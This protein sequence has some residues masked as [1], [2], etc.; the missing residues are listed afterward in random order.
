MLALRMAAVAAVFMLDGRTAADMACS[1]PEGPGLLAPKVDMLPHCVS[2]RCSDKQRWGSGNSEAETGG[3]RD[4]Q[5]GGY[6]AARAHARGRDVIVPDTCWTAE[7]ALHVARPG[8]RVFFR[9]GSF[10]WDDIAVVRRHMHIAGEDKSCLLGAWLLQAETTGLFQGV[11]CAAKHQGEP[12]A[13]LADATVTSLSASW[14]FEDCELRAVRGPVLRLLDSANVTLLFC[15][16]GGVGGGNASLDD[17]LLRATDAVVA[18]SSS[19][20]LLYRCGIDDTGDVDTRPPRDLQGNIIS[21]GNVAT[22]AALRAP[23]RSGVMAEGAGRHGGED[24]KPEHS[25]PGGIRVFHSAKAR[26]E[27][28]TSTNNDVTITL[29]GAASVVVRKCVLKCSQDSFALLRAV[30]CHARSRLVLRANQMEGEGFC[31]TACAGLIKA[32]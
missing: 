11:C 28:C 15:N 13:G 29:S 1:L 21:H 31:L 3:G 25:L 7:E 20:A 9:E 26:L 12:L 2:S 17:D 27:Q 24:E 8:D 6:P 4:E 30:R 18:M 16:I 32:P 19:N 23:R 5:R 22:G 14:I 10:A